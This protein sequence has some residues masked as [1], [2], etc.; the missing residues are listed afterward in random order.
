VTLV[1][2]SPSTLFES[3][4]SGITTINKSSISGIERCV[5]DASEL[6][7]R[8][9][10]GEDTIH[11]TYSFSD[12]HSRQ[13]FYQAALSCN[14]YNMTSSKP[15]IESVEMFCSIIDTNQPV[16]EKIDIETHYDI[17]IFMIKGGDESSREGW[18]TALAS[19]LES[20]DC[21]EELQSKTPG[22]GHNLACFS[23]SRI[24]K[25]LSNIQ[26]STSM[27][28]ET[29]DSSVLTFWVGET[30]Y[31]IYASDADDF[32][33]CYIGS[34]QLDLHQFRHLVA[35]G[36]T[37]SKSVGLSGSELAKSTCGSDGDF[38]WRSSP[39]LFEG[40]SM[41]TS[42]GSL[43]FGA[44][45]VVRAP[46]LVPAME[47]PNEVKPNYVLI[48]DNL[49]ATGVS[50]ENGEA[51]YVYVGA[52]FCEDRRTSS[53]TGTATPVWQFDRQIGGQSQNSIEVLQLPTYSA[54]VQYLQTQRLM[55]AVMDDTKKEDD[56]MIGYGFLQLK[57]CLTELDTAHEFVLD[58]TF[59]MQTTCSLTG[60]ISAHKMES[61]VKQAVTKKSDAGGANRKIIS[62][63]FRRYDLDESGTINTYEELQQLCTN[64]SV[65]MELSWT[66]GDIDAKVT[67]AGNMEEN[68]WDLDNFVDWFAQEFE[69]EID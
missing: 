34:W 20:L 51:A 19:H 23:K 52:Q 21:L 53:K 10:D 12:P 66:V 48:L 59:F 43:G 8:Y 55:I 69:V 32:E 41:Q 47:M 13:Q 64:L 58:L 29:D 37:V 40:C 57:K 49:R 33:D 61:Q 22:L 30:S 39:D 27:G 44:Y 50:F 9:E 67:S 15:N 26:S 38:M 63:Y 18:T 5:T 1:V 35:M 2:D 36:S 3:S 28:A 24:S 16:P 54:D 56:P 4:P 17:Y 25:F 14:P 11:A 62:Q 68:N 31:G 7:I 65:R 46:A 42:S 60:R 45:C 6:V